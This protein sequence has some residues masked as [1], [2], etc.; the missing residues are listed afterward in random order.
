[1]CV[2]L[3]H[4]GTYLLTNEH[5]LDRVEIAILTFLFSVSRMILSQVLSGAWS[6]L[7]GK[8]W[9][10]WETGQ[11]GRV[12]RHEAYGAEKRRWKWPWPFTQESESKNLYF[13]RTQKHWERLVIKP[14]LYQTCSTWEHLRHLYVEAKYTINSKCLVYTE[15]SREKSWEILSLQLCPELPDQSKNRGR[16]WGWKQII[17]SS[18]WGPESWHSKK[19]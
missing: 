2:K 16:K 19:N 4:C 8:N 12:Q 13:P 1:M 3:Y 17:L 7:V 9:A 15:V 11:A 10:S 5:L 6:N 14:S 18:L